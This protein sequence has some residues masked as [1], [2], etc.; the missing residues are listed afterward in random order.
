MS[1]RSGACQGPSLGPWGWIG[2]VDARPCQ[3][4]MD[5]VTRVMWGRWGHAGVSVCGGGPAFL[6]GAFVVKWALRWG[7]GGS[8]MK[9]VVQ[10][11]GQFPVQR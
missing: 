6:S 10:K 11:E 5:G 2:S 8:G 1:A 9:Q 3:P 7:K 4:E